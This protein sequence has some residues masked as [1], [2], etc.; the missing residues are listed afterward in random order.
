MAL[1]SHW[2]NN[3]STQYYSLS[4]QA[5]SHRS[6]DKALPSKPVLRLQHSPE[7]RGVFDAEDSISKALDGRFPP[8][9]P[10]SSP[11][12]MITAKD[13]VSGGILETPSAQLSIASSQE[14]PFQIATATQLT[15]QKATNT[16]I[17]PRPTRT[18]L[19]REEMNKR[20][21]NNGNSSESAG[22]NLPPPRVMIIRDSGVKRLDSPSR[23]PRLSRQGAGSTYSQDYIHSSLSQIAQQSSVATNSYTSQDYRPR[24]APSESA[25]TRIRRS[26]MREL[27]LEL[28]TPPPDDQYQ[29]SGLNTPA[30]T[31]P[32][33]PKLSSRTVKRAQGQ[34]VKKRNS[35]AW[36]ERVS[37]PGYK[38]SGEKLNSFNLVDTSGSS[39]FQPQHGKNFAGATVN[40][41]S[42]TSLVQDKNVVVSKISS[43]AGNDKQDKEKK[44][45]GE[46][47]TNILPKHNKKSAQIMAGTNTSSRTS[48]GTYLRSSGSF[49]ISKGFKSLGKRVSGK[50]PRRQSTFIRTKSSKSSSDDFEFYSNETEETHLLA[51]SLRNNEVP[52]LKDSASEL[53]T[54][55]RNS[56]FEG[57]SV[58]SRTSFNE[59]PR[60]YFEDEPIV[61]M[62]SNA[63]LEEEKEAAAWKYTA[64]DF[65]GTT[66]S[67]SM[68]QPD[69]AIFG[70]KDNGGGNNLYGSSYG[71]AAQNGVYREADGFDKHKTVSNTT[72]STQRRR[73]FIPRPATGLPHHAR[74]SSILPFAAPTSETF[75]LGQEIPVKEG[76]E[77]SQFVSFFTTVFSD[78]RESARRIEDPQH[79]NEVLL[80]VMHAGEQLRLVRDIHIASIQITK[81]LYTA[82]RH[83]AVNFTRL[84]TL[85]AQ[86]HGTV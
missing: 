83:V 33:P 15:V 53:L 9:E 2:K 60:K 80:E 44:A 37:P 18:S 78:L 70:A 61:E 48:N 54:T 16:M 75:N 31:L 21:S 36:A 28:T 85:A 25:G 38:N 43:L 24:F 22:Y 35:M 51:E 84:T 81:E 12:S 23:L 34:P 66:K 77:F 56:G 73:S 20:Q 42:K 69:E 7:R 11:E 19:M 57:S 52:V 59:N 55:Y 17:S 30:C 71:S 64:D 82:Q 58:G 45:C 41:S 1:V 29:G 65:V 79:Q 68:Y 5:M 72:H 26:V 10:T 4:L 39:P 50:F 3:K 6:R 67:T 27:R 76:E 46:D 32:P 13:F 63:Q 74:K 86:L 62:N 14:S 49:G 8:L 40:S 47:D